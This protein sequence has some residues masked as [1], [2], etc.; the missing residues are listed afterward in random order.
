MKKHYIVK[1]TPEERIELTKILSNG[2][3]SVKQH[4]IAKVLLKVDESEVEG[5]VSDSAIGEELGIS[6]KTV[7]RLREKYAEGGL[8]KVFEKK[9]TPR[10]SRRKFK[11][12]EE[13]KLIVLCCSEAPEGYAR[14]SLRLL[15]DKVVELEIVDSV[16]HQ[17]IS[18]TLKKTNLNLG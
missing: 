8:K 18:E 9:F 13:A 1:L 10:L 3:T 17:T 2:N 4:R 14:W 7:Q 5:R 6:G 12:E 16:S 15:A 11:G